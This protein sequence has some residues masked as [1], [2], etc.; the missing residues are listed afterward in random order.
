MRQFFSLIHPGRISFVLM[1]SLFACTSAFAQQPVTTISDYVIFGGSNSVKI[2]SSTNIQG[3]SI[4]SFK[5]VQSTGNIICGTNNLKTNIYSGGT[6]VL[7]NSN[8]VSGKVTAANAFNAAGTILS[9]GTSASL[10]DNID[11]NGNIEIGGGTI[12]GIVTNPAGTIYKLG[13]VTIANN[14]GI[15]LLPVLPVLPAI[16]TFPAA[17][18]NDI[19]STNIISPGAYGNVT[20][21]ANITLTLSGPGVYVF[22]SFTTNGPNSSVV[23]DFKT[24]SKGNFL[25]YV[26]SDIILNKASFTM[27]NGGS[28]TR[29]YAE[30]HGTGSTCLNDKTTSFNMSNG[31]N[32]TGNPSGWLGS[33]WAPYAGIKIGS[34][35]GPSTSAVGAFW[36]GTQVSIQTGVSIMYAPFIFCTTPVV[37]AGADQAVCASIPVTLAGNSPAAGITGKWTI[38]SGPSTLVNQLA[39]NTVYNTK[40]TPLAGSVGTYLLRWTLTNGT[41]VATDD[42]NVTVNGLPVI[43]GNLNVCILSST[44]LTGSAQPDATTPWTSANTAVA[45]IN[46]GGVVAGVS[47][48]TSL[49]TYKNSNGCTATASVTVNALPTISGTLSICSASTTTLTGSA[50][51]DA[52]TPWVSATPSV[53]SITNTG[54]VTGLTAGTSVISYKNNNGCTITATVTVNALPLFVNAGS[55]KPLSFNNNTTLNGTSSSASDTYNWTATNGGMIV[56]ASNTASIG[57]SAAGNY[58]LTAT[59]LAGCSAS[60]EVIVTSKVNNIIGSELLS[61]Y[62]NFIPN[63]TSDFFSIDAN[64]NVLIEITVKEGHYAEVLALLTN[65]LNATVYGLTDIRSNGA[66]AFKITGLFPILH[67]LNLNIS[68][69]ADIINFVAPLYMPSKGFGLATTQGDAAIRTNFIRNGYGLYGEG[70]KIGVLSDSYNTIA[71]N[72]AGVDVGNGDLPAGDSVQVVKDYPYGKGVDEGRAMLQIVHDMAPRSKL[73]FRTGFITA[74]D[75]AAGIR[76]LKQNNCDVIVDDITYI[77]EPFFQDGAVA[78]A[79]NE[80]SSQGVAYFCAAGNYANKSYQG[81]FTAAIPP[82]GLTLPGTPHDFGGGDIFQKVSLLKG[83][84]TI[85]LQWQDNIY[86]LGQTQNATINDLDI[87]LTN[88]KGVSLFGYNRNNIGGDP[89]E[90]L[91]FSVAADGETDIIIVRA[92]GTSANLN[93]KYII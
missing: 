80:V 42:V 28:V 15:P 55:D 29:I 47:A 77:T 26:Y 85:V 10:G 65:P 6:V 17:G 46:A 32:G 14:K 74:G 36:S 89:I 61:L 5:L 50:T 51:A 63:S 64:D 73:A 19:T 88:N 2:G 3:G 8:A 57:V 25:I 7:A 86:S 41:C 84:Y 43:G 60:D 4:G 93:F 54:I 48:G 70:I 38:I 35:T 31:S 90:T 52:A 53:S 24:T 20:L 62:Q 75:M 87:Y 91:P 66:S 13:G 22:K 34:P 59:S 67:L 68:P 23:Y 92:A 27:V 69:A 76:E 40:F 83:T 72:P 58:L 56:S 71:G 39:D 16:T 21:G 78:Q 1:A 37:N 33:I 82:V 9:V 44:T 79:V 49:V 11:V 12:S 45:T 18:T 30:T 81:N